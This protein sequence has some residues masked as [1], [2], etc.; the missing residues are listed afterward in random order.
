LL[1][2]RRRADNDQ[3][4]FALGPYGSLMF[5]SWEFDYDCTRREWADLVGYRRVFGRKSVKNWGTPQRPGLTLNL[6]NPILEHAKALPLSSPTM[7]R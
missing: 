7:P 1:P 4:A 3:A 5:D 6:E 2:D